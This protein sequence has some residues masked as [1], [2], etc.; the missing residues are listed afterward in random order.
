MKTKSLCMRLLIRCAGLLIGSFLVSSSYAQLTLNVA[1]SDLNQLSVGD[2]DF[3][4]LGTTHWYFTVTV[5]P[6]P[7]GKVFLHGQIDITLGDG[8]IYNNAAFFET[9]PFSAPRTFTNIELG[10]NSDIK[11]KGRPESDFNQAAKDRIQND[12]LATGR[13]PAGTYHF[14]L[15]V[16]DT[17]NT[18]IYAMSEFS[19]SLTNYSRL[20]LIAPR[21]NETVPNPF[22]IFQWLY[23]GDQIELSIYERLPHHNSKEEA[24]QGTPN[25][26]V[27][28]S[29]LVGVRSFQYPSSGVRLL[30][31]GKTYVWR[32]RGL[33]RGTGGR[34]GEI[35][36]EVWQFTVASTGGESTGPSM[37]QQQNVINQLQLI[38]GLSSQ[39][40]NQLVSGNLQLTGNVTDEN[41]R[42]ISIAELQ[43]I[44][45][46][47]SQNPDKIIEV[48]IINRP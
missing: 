42:Q 17:F 2:I 12:A 38:T 30:R 15:T 26:V 29:Q 8:T 40:L 16:T 24:A 13:L 19:L 32:A 25:L 37:S 11:L 34:G 21:D 28:P 31:P 9:R 4:N 14:I 35:N 20:D 10:P 23:D 36:S 5:G 45:N 47:L 22:P 18:Y 39:I 44:L 48:Q 33:P 41:G 6:S 3:Q 46:D 1:H 7:S 43:N 27:P